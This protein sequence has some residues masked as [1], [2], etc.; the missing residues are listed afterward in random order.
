[1]PGLRAAF[2]P[3]TF[4]EVNG[5]AHTS[6]QFEAFARRRH[7]PFLSVHAG[8]Q[9]A[10]STSG[11]VRTVEL[12]RGSFKFGLDAHL[13]YD[14]FLWRYAAYVEQE[15]R[16]F[17]VDLIHVT[18]PGDMGMLGLLLARRLG[19]PLVVS[20]HTSLHEY[21]GRRLERALSFV[22]RKLSG[23]CSGMIERLALRILLSFYRK[24]AVILA[25]NE[26]LRQLLAEATGRP[27]FLMK[28]G[29]DTTLF[30]PVHRGRISSAFRIG[31]VG[32][33]TA[34][35]NVR[36]LAELARALQLLG[37]DNFEIVIVGEGREESWLR[38]NVPHAVFTGVLRGESLAA[39]YASLDLFVFPSRTD[40]FGNVILEALA[41]GVPAVVTSAGGP[42]F[43]IEPGVTGLIAATDWEF[44]T[45]VNRMMTDS[46][47]HRC[48]R[49]AA[50][51]YAVH[52]SWDTVFE[53]VYLSYELCRTAEPGVKHAALGSA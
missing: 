37:R 9:T 17:G 43:L 5:V 4:Q 13:D 49:R 30:S 34:E 15:I 20:W 6:R 1:M 8:P 19:L 18:G 40:T 16:D 52:Q 39:I 45:A 32:R 27:A 28:R 47:L 29:V 46:S 7:I 41:S 35:K 33:L 22:G 26:E 38:E 24:A 10:S 21:A 50:R 53:Q 14:P 25:P 11:S 23:A 3:D 31:Y 2:L 36:F 44:V 48:M 42:R 51:E 12:K